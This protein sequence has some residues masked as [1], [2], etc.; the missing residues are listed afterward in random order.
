MS[1]LHTH[2]PEYK[3]AHSKEQPSN[4]HLQKLHNL[5]YCS[6]RP[7]GS[8]MSSYYLI[9][10]STEDK[11]NLS[12]YI[13]ITESFKKCSKPITVV[14]KRCAVFGLFKPWL[15]GSNFTSGVKE[16]LFTVLSCVGTELVMGGYYIQCVL[17]NI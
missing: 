4:E 12:S 10:A 14:G 3:V 11:I 1:Y 13:E 6:G 2:P 5:N 9:S 8:V 17:L 15:A 7:G 16:R